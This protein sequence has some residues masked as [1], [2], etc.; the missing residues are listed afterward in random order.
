[1]GGF[2][3]AL[4]LLQKLPNEAML[5]FGDTVHLPFGPRPADEVREFSLAI[6]S[7][8]IGQGAKLVIIA[9]NT[10]TVAGLAACRAAFPDTPILGMIE[11]GCTAALAASRNRSVAVVG[12]EGTIDSREAERALLARDPGVQIVARENEELLRLAEQGGGVDPALLRR[13]VQESIPP[14][15]AA[16]ADTLL[17]ACTDYACI[18][19]TIDDVVPPGVTV[20][21]PAEAVVDEAAR[22]LTE[23]GLL[24]EDADPPRHRFCLSSL[25]AVPQFRD[26]GEAFLGIQIVALE[27][28]DPHTTYLSAHLPTF[29]CYCDEAEWTADPIVSVQSRRE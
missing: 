18:R 5:Y 3:V 6:T 8:L 25:T 11:P 2:S 13:L 7:F 23:R 12:T 1:M 27:G 15:L 14:A 16:G 17:L 19:S 21:D 26:C 4:P 9:C 10:A 20:I 22:I 24:R 28:V 29:G